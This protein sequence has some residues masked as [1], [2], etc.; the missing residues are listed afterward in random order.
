MA[1]GIDSIKKVQAAEE[2]AK[3]IV[4]HAARKRDAEVAKAEEEAAALLKASERESEGI[5]QKAFERA[6]AEI[7]I[8]EKGEREKIKSLVSRI[9]KLKLSQK[10]L[11]IVADQMAKEI[12]S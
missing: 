9:S 4:E 8:R 6:N 2:R 3:G 1:G 12:V 11:A 5:R 7:A 10:R